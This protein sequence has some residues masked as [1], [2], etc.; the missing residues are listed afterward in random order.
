[1]MVLIEVMRDGKCIRRCD[2][3]CHRAAVG[4][5]SRCCCGG[6]LRGIE[7]EGINPAGI[8]SEFLNALRENVRLEPGEYVQ[9]RIGA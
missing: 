6:V 1:M 5:K 7:R 4:G 8:S 3:R 9:L 2:A